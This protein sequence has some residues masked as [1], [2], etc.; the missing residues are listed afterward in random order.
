MPYFTFSMNLLLWV[1]VNTAALAVLWINSLNKQQ[2]IPERL[3]AV[4]DQ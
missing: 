4:P 3:P 1:P 2:D